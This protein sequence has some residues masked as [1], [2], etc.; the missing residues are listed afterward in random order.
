M[1]FALTFGGGFLNDGTFSSKSSLVSRSLLVFF[2]IVVV[3]GSS[4]SVLVDGPGSGSS[5]GQGLVKLMAG[6]GALKNFAM[7]DRMVL[8]RGKGKSVDLWLQFYLGLNNFLHLLY[9][10]QLKACKLA[11]PLHSSDRVRFRSS[12]SPATSLDDCL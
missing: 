10:G 12:N 3:V 4:S 2:G 1:G 7:G 9:A 6:G 5:S 8:K 11:G